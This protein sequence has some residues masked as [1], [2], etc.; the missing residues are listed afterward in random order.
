MFL[1]NASL[2]M[3]VRWLQYF[4]A[5]SAQLEYCARLANRLIC[6]DNISGTPRAKYYLARE[7]LRQEA[8]IYEDYCGL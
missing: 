1:L 6:W 5:P 2:S 3:L 7:L 4:L 8:D